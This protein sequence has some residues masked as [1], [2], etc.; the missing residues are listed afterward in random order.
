MQGVACCPRVRRKKHDTLQIEWGCAKQ[1][2]HPLSLQQHGCCVDFRLALQ[3]L[4]LQLPESRYICVYGG[5]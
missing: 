5:R 4:V 3:V 2:I 1:R